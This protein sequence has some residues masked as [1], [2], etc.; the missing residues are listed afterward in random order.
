MAHTMLEREVIAH[1]GLNTLAPENT[2]SAFKLAAEHGL[3]WIETDV[4]ILGDGTPVVVH[5]TLLDRTTNRSGYFYDLTEA[6]LPSIDAGAWFSKQYAG[7]P[8]PTLRQLVD[9]MNETGL[10]ANI[11]LKSNERGKD[12]SLKLIENTL[13]ELDRLDPEREIIISSFNHLLLHHVHEARPDLAIGALFVKENLWPDWRS[14][15]ELV[16]ATYI[17]PEDA[18]LTPERVAAFRD[19]GFGVNVWT[20]NSKARANELF[21]WGVTGVFTDIAHEFMA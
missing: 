12:A 4:D 15:L 2:L 5:D 16:G 11:E 10:N 19:A 3:S 6:D 7:E 20:V 14:I 8:L 21:N 17:H 9:L 18:S 1:R 13:A